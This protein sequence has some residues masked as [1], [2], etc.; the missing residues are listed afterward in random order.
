MR[1]RSD[2]PPIWLILIA[3]LA[4]QRSL[5]AAFAASF[6]ILHKSDRHTVGEISHG[7]RVTLDIMLTLIA[8][9][10][11]TKLRLCEKAP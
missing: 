10:K 6:D 9:Q 7:M 5:G 2:S 8:N 1:G 11:E 4:G 3:G